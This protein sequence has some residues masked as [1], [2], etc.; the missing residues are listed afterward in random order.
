MPLF[1]LI[2]LFAVVFVAPVYAQTPAPPAQISNIVNVLENIIKLL[3]PAAG[4][5]FFIML[6]VGGYK[7][8]TSGGDPKAVGSARSTLTYAVIGIILV[9]ASWLILQLIATFTGA[10]VTTVTIPTK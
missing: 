8:I 6:L 4:I 7:F 2:T 1:I 5:A 3:A 10:D 9:V